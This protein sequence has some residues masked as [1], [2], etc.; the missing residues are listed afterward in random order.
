MF[1][2]FQIHREHNMLRIELP[3]ARR[4]IKHEFTS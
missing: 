4:R 3:A 2:F 1:L